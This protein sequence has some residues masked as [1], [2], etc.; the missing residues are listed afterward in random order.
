MSEDQIE[1]EEQTVH[2]SRAT[3]IRALLVLALLAGAGIG[4][5]AITMA[6]DETPEAAIDPVDI[7]HPAY[8]QTG[9][10]DTLGDV[11]EP[12]SDLTVT[13]GD[14]TGMAGAIAVSRSFTTVPLPF[15]ALLAESY[16][17]SVRLSAQALDTDLVC[18][19]IGGVVD[20]N[21]ALTIGLKEVGGLGHTGIA[22]LSPSA[23]GAATDLLIF[24]TE[25]DSTTEPVAGATPVASA[26]DDVEANA[27][28]PAP[29]ADEAEDISTE[30]T[31]EVALTEWAINMPAELEA[32]TAI[33]EVINDGTVPHTFQ[34]SGSNLDTALAAPI[35]PGE[36]SIL[37]VDLTPGI[38]VVFCPLGDGAH[39]EIGMQLEVTV[40]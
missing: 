6:Q 12:L 28:A 34:I 29:V 35:G 20:V 15:E 36:T 40:N 31:V 19:E 18:G 30:E 2:R 27:A 39:R 11:V 24:M 1:P 16:A 9:N 14:P 21:G 32:G 38:Y 4:A 26:S 23:D 5:G 17:L 33:F 25:D 22:Y 13:A 10:C 3:I 37:T 8:V 7:G